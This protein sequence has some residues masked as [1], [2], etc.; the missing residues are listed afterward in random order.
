MVRAGVGFVR[1]S[2]L[3]FVLDALLRR[4]QAAV[5]VTFLIVALSIVVVN[6]AE[7]G[8]FLP[9]FDMAAVGWH[10][11]VGVV[12]GLANFDCFLL[13]V[14]GVLCSLLVG[15]VAPLAAAAVHVHPVGPFVLAA[16]RV[17]LDHLRLVQEESDSVVFLE[18][19]VFPTVRLEKA[20]ALFIG[21]RAFRVF[22]IGLGDH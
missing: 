2:L 1:A 10:F 5:R 15:L 6:L 4:V 19:L 13:A 3:D 17:T 12:N 18:V 14:L 20:T 9:G 22:L 21:N 16:V 11:D 8:A 7:I